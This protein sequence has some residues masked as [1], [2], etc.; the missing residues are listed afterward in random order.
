M[1]CS[2][3]RKQ[4]EVVTASV[5]VCT[6]CPSLSISPGQVE[7]LLPMPWGRTW[8]RGGGELL[9]RGGAGIGEQSLSLSAG[10]RLLFTGHPCCCSPAFPVS[11]SQRGDLSESRSWPPAT[12]STGSGIHGGSPALLGP[13]SLKPSLIPHWKAPPIPLWGPFC[14]GRETDEVRGR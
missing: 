14:P 5:A 8:S 3:F 2:S 1:E 9:S 10:W 11:N 4:A 12:C 13:V 7:G 6:H